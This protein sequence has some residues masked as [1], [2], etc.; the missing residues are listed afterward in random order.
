M[1]LTI[2]GTQDVV[3]NL[4]K[5]MASVRRAGAMAVQM[6]GAETVVYAKHNA[7]WTD[8]TGNARRSIHAEA[9]NGNLISNIGIG[10]FYGKYLELDHG[11]KYRIVHPAVFSYGK[12]QLIKNLE[13]IL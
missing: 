12:A 6:A 13:G 8:R 7:P 4:D 5:T 9:E 3:S 1:K 2:T 10:M 11:G